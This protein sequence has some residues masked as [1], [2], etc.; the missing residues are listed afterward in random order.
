MRKRKYVA[1]AK[2]TPEDFRSALLDKIDDLS[3]LESSTNTANVAAKPVTAAEDEIIDRETYFE[4]LEGA[5][6]DDIEDIIDS[7]DTVVEFRTS[8]NFIAIVTDAVYGTCKFTFEDDELNFTGEGLPDDAAYVSNTIR[9]FYET[10]ET[11]E[12]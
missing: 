2:G 4:M 1:S 10:G 6:T 7:D 11:P 8:P 12:D 3:G 5:V 9:R